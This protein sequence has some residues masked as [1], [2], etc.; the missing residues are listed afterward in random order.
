VTNERKKNVSQ[1]RASNSEVPTEAPANGLPTVQAARRPKIQRHRKSASKAADSAST[2]I[3]P[4]P[5][6][7][8]RHSQPSASVR[9]EVPQ[10]FSGLTEAI[11][12]RDAKLLAEYSNEKITTTLPKEVATFLD[13][14][15]RRNHLMFCAMDQEFW[16]AFS[17]VLTTVEGFS[18]EA[19]EEALKICLVGAR[20][21]HRRA[22]IYSELRSVRELRKI[23]N[24]SMK[25]QTSKLLVDRYLVRESDMVKGDYES[26][27]P[28]VFTTPF[29]VGDKVVH[30]IMW[31]KQV[32]PD[33][34]GEITKIDGTRVEVQFPANTS[35]VAY[36]TEWR[37]ASKEELAPVV[38]ATDAELDE[39]LVWATSGEEEEIRYL[40]EFMSQEPEEEDM[41][42]EKEFET[43]AEA[44]EFLKTLPEKALGNIQAFSDDGG[45]RTYYGMDLDE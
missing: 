21:P 16:D 11:A 31:G 34:V 24:M 29:K 4:S 44:K 2:A 6:E 17:H 26:S 23:R 41:K 15:L 13:K 45:H 42:D 32:T 30:K 36:I 43:L 8:A 3:V 20:S 27:H 33:D 40:V 12:V 19:V 38:E 5:K 7:L 28:G 35:H 25:L 37:L 9:K 18:V 39:C 10:F 22:A 1:T 14:W